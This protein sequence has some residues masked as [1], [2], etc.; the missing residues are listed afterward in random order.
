M[1]T[2]TSGLAIASLI[3]GI[4]FLYGIG[5]ILALVFGYRARN[6]IDNSTGSLQGRGM[7]TAGIVL[8]WIGIPLAIWIFVLLS[9]L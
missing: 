9:S 4:L 8:G 7:A 6:D 2:K 5:S 1:P 3:L